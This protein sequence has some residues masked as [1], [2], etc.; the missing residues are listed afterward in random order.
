VE[1]SNE[2]TSSDPVAEVERL[3]RENAALSC[4]LELERLKMEELEIVVVSEYN[5]EVGFAWR[6]H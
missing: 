4:I 3:E 2:V 6:I 1:V 5:D